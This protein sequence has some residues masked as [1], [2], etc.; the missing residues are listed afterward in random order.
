LT[1]FLDKL[2]PEQRAAVVHGEGPLMV[3]AGAG[4]GKTRV[5]THRIARLIAVG[6]MGARDILA[7]T[8]TNKAAG[9][10]RERLYQL[11]GERA[12]GMW[13]GTFHSTCARL[14]RLH[15]E[16]VR[17]TRDFAIF[18]DDDQKR[19]VT[20]ILKEMNVSERITPRAVMSRIDKAKNAGLVPGENQQ[21]DYV[22]DVVRRLYPIYSERLQRE[23]AVDF[24]DLLLKVLDLFADAELGPRLSARFQHVLVDEF[25]DTNKVQYRLV[26]HLSSRTRNLCVVGDDDQSIYAWRGAEPR[27]LL[28]FDRDYADARVVKLERNYRSTSVILSAANAVIARNVDRH[29]KALWTEREGGEPIL[30]EECLDERH[31]GEFIAQAMNG[32]RA[33]EGRGYGDLAVLYRTHAQSRA[34]EEALRSRRI[35]YKIVGGISFFQ[36]REV[37]D[38]TEYLRLLSNPQADTAFER[39]VN[40]PTRGIGDTTID[41]VRAH[42]REAGLPMLEAARS[43]L[44]VP[45]V[46]LGAAAKRKLEGFLELIDG[47]RAVVEAKTPVALIV[48]QVIE[49]SDYAARLEIEDKVDG[50]DRLRNLSELV[51]A[52]A[53]YDAEAGPEATL[54]G[55]N[56]RIALTA[57]NDAEDGRGETVTLMTIHAA[58]GLEFPVVFVAG[59]EEGMFPSLREGDLDGEIEEERRLAYVAF[60]RAM[61]RIVLT[62]AKTRRSYDGIRANPPSRFLGELP[63]ECVAVRARP[64]PVPPQVRRPSSFGGSNGFPRRPPVQADEY[65]EVDQRGQG[66]DDEPVYYVDDTGD[67]DPIFPRGARVRHRI[68]GV[69]EIQ[70]GSGRGPDRKLTVR[71]PGHGV[72]TII[73]RFVERVA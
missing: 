35:P 31:E 30:L 71:F 45:N 19:L 43:A 11:L 39:V 41:R 26:R 73:A 13:I 72:K 68:F 29:A 37:K 40:V 69:G 50:P 70:D 42:A 27:N 48:S 4:T 64:R 55:F 38:I 36:R 14:L 47:L 22:D 53:A 10:M 33:Q 44:N 52:A 21:R 3:L 12:G 16:R 9:E 59:L 7:V 32:L 54:V 15:A 51:A 17:L 1:D 46:G 60:T 24:N 67:D 6:G 28:D 65:A 58:K 2:N 34:L 18:D 62:Y 23:N 49:R 25:Q 66:S 56:E 20:G 5:L 63:S 8:F 57:S 61:E